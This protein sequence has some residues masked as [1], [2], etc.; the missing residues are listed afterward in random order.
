MSLTFLP[1][2]RTSV[3]SQGLREAQVW[4]APGNGPS[5]KHPCKLEAEMAC[6]SAFSAVPKRDAVSVSK[7][8]ELRCLPSPAY[9]SLNVFS[10]EYSS[11]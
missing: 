4:A 3:W 10:L 2:S 8:P 1:N 9:V 6:L 7:P 5:R 11:Y